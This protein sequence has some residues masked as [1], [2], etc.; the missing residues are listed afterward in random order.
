MRITPIRFIYFAF[1]IVTIYFVTSCVNSSSTNE[2]V[3]INFTDTIRVEDIRPLTKQNPNTL[4][5]AISSMT[6]PRETFTYYNALLNLI[7]SKTGRQIVL[8]QRKTY[9]E[10][11]NLLKQNEVDLA[12]ICTGAFVHGYRDTAFTPLVAPIRNGENKYRAYLIVHK[13]SEIKRFSDLRGKKFSFTDSLSTTGM[14]YPQKKL[15]ELGVTAE[16]FFSKVYFSNAH[17]NSIELV[18]RKTVDAATVNSLIYDYQLKHSPEILKELKIIEK[19]EWYAMPPIVVSLGIDGE[20]KNELLILLL[21]LN[22][23]NEGLAILKGLMID[24][25]ISVNG[26][27]YESVRAVQHACELQLKRNY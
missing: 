17:D 2:H 3:S 4:R 22:K 25:Y 19:S 1:L 23:N 15:N 5:I 8:V 14:F 26:S 20:L 27:E 24:K 10:I 18:S 6:S 21:N 11:N 9:K 12:F 13:D 16:D 7:E